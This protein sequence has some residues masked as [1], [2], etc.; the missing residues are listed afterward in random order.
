M[1]RIWVTGNLSSYQGFLEV[2]YNFSS[3]FE[4]WEVMRL[5][6]SVSWSSMLRHGA[7]KCGP[8]KYGAT[9]KQIDFTNNSRISWVH[10]I[11]KI[12]GPQ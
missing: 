5:A 7:Q 2:S 6:F 12:G 8:P 11:A 4:R 1:I 3:K 10:N 9:N